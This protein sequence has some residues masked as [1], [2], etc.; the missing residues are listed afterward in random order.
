MNFKALI[1]EDSDLFHQY[2]GS[3]PFSTYEYSFAA[4]YQWRKLCHPQFCLIDDALVVLKTVK[5]LGSHFMQPINMDSAK[6]DG[7]IARLLEYKKSHPELKYLFGDVEASFLEQL[8][9]RYGSSVTYVE[10]ADNYDYIYNSSDLL[11]LSGKKYHRKKNQY[12]QFVHNYEY[13]I[14]G[15]S[16]EQ[17]RRDCLDFAARWYEN[18]PQDDL[19]LEF[20]LDGVRD[21]LNHLDKLRVLGIAVYVHDQIVGFAFGE[22]VNDRMA[23]IHCEKG[24][25]NYSGVYA[26]LNRSLVEAHFSEIS[27]INRQEDMGLEGLR[28]AKMAY[29]PTQ[30]E[31]KFLVDIAP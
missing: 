9:Q 31:R 20:E 11:S 4:L 18:N 21:V 23:V 17:V 16:D 19:V 25:I 22:K 1:I 8:L 10:D 13:V 6:M 7:I 24:D 12:N 3:Y 14:K 30:L 2:L 15:L 5:G 26:F 29:N 27:L 28:R